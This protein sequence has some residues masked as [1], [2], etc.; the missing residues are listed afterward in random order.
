MDALRHTL[1]KKMREKFGVSQLDSHT[2]PW[3]LHPY[4]P[5][6]VGSWT[7]LPVREVLRDTECLQEAAKDVKSQ[8]II[9]SEV[10]AFMANG[11]GMQV[12]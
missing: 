9:A 2:S 12:Q 1:V 4:P 3:L 7:N 5:Y 8:E 11:G 10:S 6:I